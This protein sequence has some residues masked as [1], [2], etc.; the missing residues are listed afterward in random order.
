M[1]WRRCP[2]CEEAPLEIRSEERLY[3]FNTLTLTVSDGG[4]PGVLSLIEE[5][6]RDQALAG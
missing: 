1:N 6:W 5:F 4:D 2:W 3:S